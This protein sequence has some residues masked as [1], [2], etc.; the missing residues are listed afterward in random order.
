MTDWAQ[1]R[2]GG[3]AV[4]TDRPLSDLVAELSALLRSPDP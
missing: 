4:P 3:F 1:V 2:A